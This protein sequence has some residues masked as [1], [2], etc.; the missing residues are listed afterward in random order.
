MFLNVTKCFCAAALL[1]AALLMPAGENQFLLEFVVC[2]GA[3][4]VASQAARLQEHLWTLGFVALALLFN[5]ILAVPV[6]GA[7][8]RWLDVICMAA[9]L[10]SLFL[11][12]SAPLRSVPSITAQGARP[13]SL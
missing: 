1:A 4:L 13:E 3:I 5:P 10:I 7:V 12:R 11:F 9:F 2:F 8:L 6:S